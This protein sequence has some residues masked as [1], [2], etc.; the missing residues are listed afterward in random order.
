VIPATD[1]LDGA[2]IPRRRAFSRLAWHVVGLIAA[3]LVTWLAL[4]GYQDP[5]LM[6]ELANW[7]L[8]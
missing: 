8:C 5:A 2:A 3:A 1:P 7:R 6:L 4:R